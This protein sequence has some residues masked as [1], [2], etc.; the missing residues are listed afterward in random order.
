VRIVRRVSLLVALAL[1]AVP[2]TITATGAQEGPDLSFT[3]RKTVVGTGAPSAVSAD[4]AYN[5]DA[6][7]TVLDV[8]NFDAH[9]V[10][11]ATGGDTDWQIEDGAWVLLGGSG[12]GGTCIFT[13]TTSGGASSTSWTCAYEF[14]PI[15]APESTQIERA[16][17]PAASGGGVGPVDVNWADDNSVF[18]QSS[19]VVF[20]NTFTS[21]PV[22]QPTPA[23]Q[24]VAQPA[25]T[26]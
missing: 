9:G 3:V 10:P 14:D 1:A 24:V 13:E 25:F 18:S 16:G 6:S 15:E 12:A 21:A 8:L 4:C 22:E 20:T 5:S 7:A 2:L 26:G 19:T 11:V 17:C 23:A